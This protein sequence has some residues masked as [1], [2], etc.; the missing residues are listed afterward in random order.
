MNISKIAGSAIK[1][2]KVLP[3]QAKLLAAGTF[4]AGLL[5]G[6][7]INCGGK[8]QSAKQEPQ[9]ELIGDTLQISAKQESKQEKP[10]FE[11]SSPQVGKDGFIKADTLFYPGTNKPEC[12]KYTQKGAMQN[13]E[14]AVTY[15]ENFRED[16]SLESFTTISY[17]DTYSPETIT[18]NS[19]GEMIEYKLVPKNG[20]YYECGVKDDEGWAYH[21]Y[22]KKDRLIESSYSWQGGEQQYTYTYN[23][24]GTVG[25][26]KKRYDTPVRYELKDKNGHLIR[27][28]DFDK[29]GVVK[30]TVT[31]KYDKDGF[32]I[33]NDT[34]W[35]AERGK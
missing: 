31:P 12:I 14:S 2:V 22:D 28:K 5:V 17:S 30:Y 9:T 18:R 33:K 19:K 15:Q 6:T 20:S 25:E 4:G 11:Y 13:G 16:G 8:A 24:D 21:T 27:K 32:V 10:A 26:L 1:A 7:L 3:P 23:S 35:N 29:Q 34:V